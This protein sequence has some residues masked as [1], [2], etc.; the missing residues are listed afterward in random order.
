MIIYFTTTD[1]AKHSLHVTE[2][3]VYFDPTDFKLFRNGLSEQKLKEYGA[4]YTTDLDDIAFLIRK[5]YNGTV[6]K[7]EI[8]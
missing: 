3:K 4:V 7:I 1:G 8:L 6:D 5:G 2:L